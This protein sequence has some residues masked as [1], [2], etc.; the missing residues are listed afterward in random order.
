[1]AGKIIFKAKNCKGYLGVGN[2]MPLPVCRKKLLAKKC[3]I[4]H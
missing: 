2:L 1:M 3:S 4:I